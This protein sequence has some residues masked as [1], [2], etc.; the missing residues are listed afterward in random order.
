MFPLFDFGYRLSK[1]AGLA[2]KDYHSVS[3]NVDIL[4]ARVEGLIVYPV[5]KERLIQDD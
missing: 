3:S 5:E 4:F 2:C 1:N